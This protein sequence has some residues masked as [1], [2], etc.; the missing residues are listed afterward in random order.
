MSVSGLKGSF[1]LTAESIDKEVKHVA[2]GVF[3][4]GNLTDD[5]KFQTL[6]VGRADVNLIQT[7]KKC[8]RQAARFKFVQFDDPEDAYKKE[9]ELFHFLRPK[10]NTQHPQRP[11][12]RDWRCPDCGK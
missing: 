9:C 3:T 11:A 2:P 7:L 6:Y 1:P 4:L 10:A 8:L 5:G 12:T